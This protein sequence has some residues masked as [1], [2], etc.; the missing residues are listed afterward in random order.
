MTNDI[1]RYTLSTIE[2]IK[3]RVRMKILLIMSREKSE[4]LRVMV[5][6]RT[7]ALRQKVIAL[8]DRNRDREAFELLFKKADVHSY[9]PPGRKAHIRPAMTLIEDLL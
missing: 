8:L 4:D 3:R 6:V 9:L 5:N 1:L 2:R 7:T